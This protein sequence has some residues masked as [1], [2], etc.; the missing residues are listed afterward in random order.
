[1]STAGWYPDP[2]GNSNL[3]RYWDGE[4]WTTQVRPS[5]TPKRRRA[6]LLAGLAAVVV[7][8][9]AG[10]V[11]T[12][13]TRTPQTQS[14]GSVGSAPFG[15]YTDPPAYC[16][17]GAP[18]HRNSYP[19]DGWLH[20]GG[21]TTRTPAEWRPGNAPRLPLASDVLI[22]ETPGATIALGALRI[23]DVFDGASESL[24][25]VETCLRAPNELLKGAPAPTGPAYPV[26]VPGATSALRR[27][28]QLQGANAGAVSILI[29]DT[30]APESLGLAITVTT[31]GDDRG[32]AAT[33]LALAEL[34]AG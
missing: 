14:A 27:D 18:S 6:P 10:V 3:Q 7:L 20:G 33:E 32:P 31:G 22:A 16:R 15:W 8:A 28:Y 30:G 1:M 23:G 2:A 17:E 26:K 5:G 11:G 9:V 12:V 34:R 29:V 13:L 25:A 24:A 19:N 21:L 4:G